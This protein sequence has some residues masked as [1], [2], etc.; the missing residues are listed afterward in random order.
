MASGLP[1]VAREDKCLED[2]LEQG[3]NGYMFTDQEGLYYGLD[4]ILF[5]DKETDYSGNALEKV[6][7]YSMQEFAYQVEQVYTKVMSRDRVFHRSRVYQDS[8]IP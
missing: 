7:K 3:K 8:R 5:R 1:V 4:Q 6:R 2:I